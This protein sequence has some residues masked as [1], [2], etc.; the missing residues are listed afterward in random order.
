MCEILWFEIRDLKLYNDS[1]DVATRTSR[2]FNAAPGYVRVMG[3]KPETAAR[4]D[5]GCAAG[6]P[7]ITRMQGQYLCSLS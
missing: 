5:G 3:P 7:R 6:T 4:R 1:L 2:E